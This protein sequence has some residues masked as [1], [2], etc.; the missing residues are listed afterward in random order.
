MSNGVVVRDRR[1]AIL[2]T[3]RWKCIS[4]QTICDACTEFARNRRAR[5]IN[6]AIYLNRLNNERYF[7]GA[8]RAEAVSS[9]CAAEVFV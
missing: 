9:A 7:A 3:G 5:L 2:A 1:I 4:A 6:Q 8:C